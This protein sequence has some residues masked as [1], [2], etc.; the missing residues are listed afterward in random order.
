[1]V[2]VGPA[3]GTP[4]SRWLPYGKMGDSEMW[5]ALMVYVGGVAVGLLA[6]NDRL[7]RR[8][9]VALAWPLGPLA[10][11]VVVCGLLAAAFLLWPVRMLVGAAAIAAILYILL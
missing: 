4:P 11:V 7:W 6:T 10:F 2:G 3:K 5:Y 1:M 9:V 8:I